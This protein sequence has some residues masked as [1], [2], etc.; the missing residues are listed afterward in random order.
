ME[1]GLALSEYNLHQVSFQKFAHAHASH[2]DLGRVRFGFLGDDRR[3][4]FRGSASGIRLR[5]NPEPAIPISALSPRPRVRWECATA[6]PCAPSAVHRAPVP[7][8]GV[9]SEPSFILPTFTAQQLTTHTNNTW[10]L[11]G[12][13]RASCGRHMRALRL[14]HTTSQWR[15][16]TAEQHGCCVSVTTVL[17]LV[18]QHIDRVAWGSSASTRV[19]R[20]LLGIAPPCRRLSR[21]AHG[22]GTS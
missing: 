12:W 8:G 7:K 17:L 16:T 22:W 6:S 5:F 15:V 4:R 21:E 3:L 14:C 9:F 1:R 13:L 18:I 2:M 10:R 19:A 11:P 20:A